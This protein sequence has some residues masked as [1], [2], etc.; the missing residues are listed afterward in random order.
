MT[1]VILVL[2]LQNLFQA[3]ISELNRFAASKYSD[4]YI[5]S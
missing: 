3:E 4:S 5:I 1:I 2:P